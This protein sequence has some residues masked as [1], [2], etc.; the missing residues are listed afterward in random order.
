MHRL[1]ALVRRKRNLLLAAVLAVAAYAGFGFLIAPGIVR[2]Q[3]EQRL[4]AA[5]HRDVKVA[6]VRL[7]PFALSVTIEG[8]AVADRDGAPFLA[9]DRLHVNYDVL[10]LVQRELELSDIEL[11]GPFVGVGLDRRGRLNFED[12]LASDDQAPPP[13]DQPAKPGALSLRVD[14]L[15]ISGARVSFSDRARA[16][17]FATTLGP[18]SFALQNFRTGRPENDGA[19]Q[20][21]GQT[22]AGERFAWKGD[23]RL[24]PIR[25]KG[26]FTF[27][28]ISLPKYA[29]YYA[30]AV[31]FDLRSGTAGVTASYDLTWG[32][33]EHVVRLVDGGLSVR[34]L[35]LAF[36]G[37]P[38]AIALPAIDVTGAVADLLGRD[39]SVA[40]VALKGGRI[41]AEVAPDGSIDL[42]RLARPRAAAAPPADETAASTPTAAP[43][44]TST[45][46]AAAPAPF[47]YRVGE[48][49]VEDVTFAARD[50]SAPRPVDVKV[51][52]ARLALAGLSSDPAAPAQLAVEA[53]VNDDGRVKLRGTLLPLRSKGELGVELAALPLPAFDAYLQPALDAR[54][55]SAELELSGRATFDAGAAPVA[56]TFEGDVGLLGLKAV[57]GPRGEE[58]L[59]WKSLRVEGIDAAPGRYA[60]GAVR[61]IEP[62]L[63]AA[64][65][66][67]GR[68]NLGV[69]A[70][71]KPPPAASA[72]GAGPET[73]KA[74]PAPAPARAP[75]RTPAAAG[76]RWSLGLFEIAAGRL[77][78]VDRSVAPAVVLDATALAVQVRGL[79]SDVRSRA[80]VD[81]R[82]RVGAAPFSMKGTLQPYL[83]GDATQLG[84]QAKAIDLTPL[85]PYFA[86][87]VGYRFEKGKLD[88]DLRY[89]VKAR[90]L[91]AQNRA[92]VDQLTLGDRTGSPDATKLPVRLGLAILTDRE[93]VIALDVPVGGSIDAP[94][95][96]LGRVIWRA[97]VNVFTKIALSPF[98]AI[99][100]LFGGGEENLEVLEFAPGQAA[101]DATAERKLSVLVK[102]LAERPAL[103]LDLEGVA[104]EAVDGPA[105][106]Q[107]ALEDA[108]RRAKWTGLRAKAPGLELSEVAVGAEDRPRLVEALWKA[109]PRAE[110]PPPAAAVVPPAEATAP[111]KVAPPGPAAAP[112]P[113]EMEQALLAAVAVP[114]EARRELAAQRAEAARSRLVEVGKID[115]GR[116]FLAEGGERAQKEKGARVYFTLK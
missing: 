64:T 33:K 86:R 112:T 20:L 2:G 100:A 79:S 99:G 18:V 21:S 42:L 104:D 46:P 110:P 96:T 75:A 78:F 63:R 74:G 29:P 89:A 3:L 68:Q 15:R 40:R 47:R 114:P 53:R 7:N 52:L 25:S 103:Q 76:P 91:D 12:L 1:A 111:A 88:L 102:A 101:L 4:A 8:L 87:Y 72:E 44:A 35:E 95:F 39:A 109:L 81:V 56:W 23:V 27:D 54:L 32:P 115:P 83:A 37:G 77:S 41:A 98:S 19:Y 60:I 51:D 69:V 116:V 66:E 84:I 24:E 85:G 13:P 31:G 50:L 6:R 9:F 97:V 71:T 93:G 11:D 73:A 61:L 22:E 16:R 70:R 57:D 34:G 38:V 108:L 107:A 48:V 113:A 67:D 90:Q 55:D 26:T 65:W 17:P 82:A 94:D 36:P 80:T 28:A 58:W 5:L 49:V 92:R 62:R 45:G 14:R 105:L 59:R 43:K 106:R 30:D 10:G